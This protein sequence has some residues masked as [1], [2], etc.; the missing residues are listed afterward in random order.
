MEFEVFAD[1]FKLAFE[2]APSLEFAAFSFEVAVKSSNDLAR[3]CEPSNDLE[4][5]AFAFAFAF[6]SEPESKSEPESESEC[7][8]TGVPCSKRRAAQ[9]EARS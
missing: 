6:D 8:A 4:F 3:E 7:R 5:E 2:S 9:R 1:A